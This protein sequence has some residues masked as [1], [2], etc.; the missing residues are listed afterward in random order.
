MKTFLWT[1]CRLVWITLQIFANGSANGEDPL[2][3]FK[4]AF[5]R[6]ALIVVPGRVMGHDVT[7][8]LDTGESVSVID[9]SLAT[10]HLKAA[11]FG[12][13]R[14]RT[15]TGT[16]LVERFEGFSRNCLSFPEK[17][18]PAVAMDLSQIATIAGVQVDV[19][20]GMDYLH[21]LVF[22]MKAGIP[23][24]VERAE[25]EHD[26]KM[27]SFPLASAADFP[28]IDVELPVLGKRQFLIDTGRGDF[29]AMKSDL[30]KLL[31][32]AD[33]AV[34]LH[35]LPA[36]DRPGA[37]TESDYV[38]R[39]MRILGTTMQNVLVSESDAN[40]I[41]LGL[42]RHFD[43]SIDFENSVVYVFP[44]SKAMNSFPLD[45]SGLW[46]VIPTASGILLRIVPKSPADV[47]G[48]KNGDQLLEINGQ[49][50]E[51]L[52]SWE[53]TELLSQSDK[54]IQL[55]VKSSDQVRDI[56]LPL[57]RN[58]EYP[59]K[60]K[61]RSTDADDFYKSLQREPERSPR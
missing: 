40:R 52:S 10:T 6:Y 4:A 23:R 11:R 5:D 31:L 44:G 14:A 60:W 51:M 61:P 20:L 56:Q 57:R 18:G 59:P 42:M 12:L 27:Q 19:V 15:A 45:A 30:L 58:F 1:H 2:D 36:T 25:F 9:T 13:D 26:S 33:E 16:L 53:I 49:N 54:T 47:A 35:E 38:I 39:E 7:C 29:V 17:T 32:K 21:P 41:G 24:F 46:S 22:E 50:A 3:A 55:K 34:L 48:I 28:R 37:K 8:L 43:F